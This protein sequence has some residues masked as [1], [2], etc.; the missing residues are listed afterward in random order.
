[1]T[2]N[3]PQWL[4]QKGIYYGWVVALV[5][6]LAIVA[7]VPGQ[8]M[9]VSVY[10]D[11]LI[12]A[13]PLDRSQ[14]SLAYLGGTLGSSFLLPFAGRVLDRIGSRIQATAAALALAA[15]LVALANLPHWT[16]TLVAWTGAPATATAWVLTLLAFLTIR[17]FG[18]GQLTMCARTMIGLWFE[19]HRGLVIGVSGVFTA[20]AFGIAPMALTS[21]IEAWT[22][23]GSLYLL[24]TSLVILAGLFALAFRRAPEYYGVAVDGGAWLDEESRKRDWETTRRV[25]FTVAEAKRTATFWIFNFGMMSPALIISGITF[26]MAHIGKLNHME[27][28]TAF[29]VFVPV[30]VLST[31]ADL[32]AGVLADRVPLKYLLGTMQIGL[33]LALWGI[34]QFASPLGYWAVALGFGLSGGVFAQLTGSAWP[35]LFGRAHLG[36]IAGVAMFWMVFGSSL[37]PYLYSLGGDGGL[38]T[39]LGVSALL[40]L[41]VLFTCPWANRPTKPAE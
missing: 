25:S 41:V 4:G 38:P 33:C 17:H 2:A 39:M 15:G 30:A 40:P 16:R 36:S 3:F 18:Q 5:G 1:M 8:T 34:T 35:K 22:W 13:L 23:Q 7:S 26:H 19:K 24:A 28:A 12:A 20:F 21:F 31:L 10:T 6:T 37:G 29:G 9:G 32:C 11:H 14:L 27:V